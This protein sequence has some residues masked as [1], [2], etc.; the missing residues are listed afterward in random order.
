MADRR[1][2]LKHTICSTC[3]WSLVWGTEE[4]T[5]FFPVPTRWM[6]LPL[7]S[8]PTCTYRDMEGRTDRQTDTTDRLTCRK[9]FMGLY[10]DSRDSSY[11]K[12]TDKVK[13]WCVCNGI[14]TFWRTYY[15]HQARKRKKPSKRH[16]LVILKSS[17][18][19]D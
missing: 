15:I 7:S 2:L 19:C 14:A 9:P 8:T 10:L 6:Y 1:S 17:F 3:D 18:Y 12:P 4:K 16:I 11:Q 5:G 13:L